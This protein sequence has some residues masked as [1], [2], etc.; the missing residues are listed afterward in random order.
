[1]SFKPNYYWNH[2]KHPLPTAIEA[3]E[4]NQEYYDTQEE[5]AQAEQIVDYWLKKANYLN[6]VSGICLGS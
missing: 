3:I 1:M 4:T 5:Q 6:T 2:Q